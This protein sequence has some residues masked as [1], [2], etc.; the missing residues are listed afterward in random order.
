MRTPTD[1]I[2]QSEAAMIDTSK[3]ISDD[4][5][6]CDHDTTSSPP[7]IPTDIHKLPADSEAAS[8][9]PTSDRKPIANPD[10]LQRRESAPAPAALQPPADDDDEKLVS[11]RSSQRLH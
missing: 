9:A 6:D 10:P 3:T 5:S 4:F 1:H 2:N 8:Y 11:E 7:K